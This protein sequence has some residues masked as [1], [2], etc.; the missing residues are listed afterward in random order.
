LERG[1]KTNLYKGRS[2][3]SPNYN[4]DRPVPPLWRHILSQLPQYTMIQNLR[5]PYAKYDTGEPILDKKTG[6]PKYPTSKLLTALKMLGINISPFN[7]DEMKKSNIEQLMRSQSSQQKF[8]E[9][10]NKFKGQGK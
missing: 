9:L 8:D 3:T 6:Q 10:M 4:E 7:L 5:Q 2:F 1:T